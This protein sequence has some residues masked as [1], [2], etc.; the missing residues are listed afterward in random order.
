MSIISFKVAKP[1][2]LKVVPEAIEKTI[3]DIRVVNN[4][5]LH[6]FLMLRSGVLIWEEY[7]RENELTTLH[8]LYSVTKSFTSSAIGLAEAQGLLSL[9]DKVY[10][11]FP[12]YSSLCDS[13]YKKGLTLKHLL[14]MGSGFS[15][16]EIEIFQ[17]TDNIIERAL[18]QPI[19]HEPGT[20]FDYYSLGSHLLSAVLNKVYPYGIY[21]YLKRKLFSPMGFGESKWME[22]SSGINMG[23]FGLELAAYDLAKFGQLY[24]QKGNWEGQQLISSSYIDAATSK[25]IS[26]AN[27]PS[28]NPDWTAGYGYQFW[29]CRMGGFRADGMDGQYIIVLPEKQVVIV[30][31]SSLKDM[32]IPLTVIQN[33]LLPAIL[34]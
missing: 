7:F 11:F 28:G 1:V 23:G 15:N 16:N 18:A 10:D 27:H 14:M 9:N 25:Q 29:K 8:P 19:I 34:D 4:L 31:T 2:D 26:N 32:Q 12:E 17:S 24:L 33:Q 5:E 20:Y 3:N 6:S 21:E 13:E 30:M 22:D